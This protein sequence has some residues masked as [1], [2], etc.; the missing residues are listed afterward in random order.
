MGETTVLQCVRKF[1][2]AIICIYDP[3]YLRAPNVED[4]CSV[5]DHIERRG[6]PGMIDST[7]C[8]HCGLKNCPMAWQGQYTGYKGKTTYVLKSVESYDTWIWHAFFENAGSN[9]LNTLGVSSLF[10]T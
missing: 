3:E 6:F 7:V 9:N 10:M 4:L 2:N 5:H 1:C 8:M